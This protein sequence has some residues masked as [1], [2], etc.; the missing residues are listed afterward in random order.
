MHLFP[1]P[2]TLSVRCLL[3]FCVFSLFCSYMPISGFQ[4]VL[5]GFLVGIKQIIP[6]QELSLLKIKAKVWTLILFEVSFSSNI[7]SYWSKVQTLTS[8]K[9][10]LISILLQWLPSLAVLLSVV[11][12]FFTTDSASHLPTLIFGTYIG[13][14]YLRYWQRK[15]ETKLKGDPS[16]EFA[17]S[18]F[19]PDFLR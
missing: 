8:S 2:A 6:D 18:T 16:D 3:V 17:F 11:V 15:T 1:S 10:L 7:I 19:F 5:S 4:G 13:W 14:I 12:S 9:M